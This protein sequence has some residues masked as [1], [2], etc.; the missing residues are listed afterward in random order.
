MMKIPTQKGEQSCTCTELSLKRRG[1]T[2][3]MHC[4]VDSFKVVLRGAIFSTVTVKKIFSNLCVTVLNSP[5]KICWFV[6]PK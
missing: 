6:L 1:K 4:S 5:T 3:N 2:C